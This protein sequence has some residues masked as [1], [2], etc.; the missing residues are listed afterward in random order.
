M[1]DGSGSTK[2]G[3]GGD[4]MMGVR[5]GLRANL[6][7]LAFLLWE[8]MDLRGAFGDGSETG[9]APSERL[10]SIFLGDGQSSG[11][12]Q[13]SRSSS[14][15]ATDLLRSGS[16]AKRTEAM[17]EDSGWSEAMIMEGEMGEEMSEGG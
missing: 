3:E 12:K 5:C 14:W 13:A 10:N 15:S 2:A 1:K 16:L 4:C 17:A 6:S 11:P 9:T 7:K 8:S